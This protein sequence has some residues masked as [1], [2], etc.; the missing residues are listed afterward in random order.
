MVDFASSFSLITQGNHL[1][2]R[3]GFSRTELLGNTFVYVSLVE[4][5]LLEVGRG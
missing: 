4:R 1:N 3:D 5:V 2:E